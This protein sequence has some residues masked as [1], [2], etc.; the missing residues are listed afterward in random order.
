MGDMSLP[1]PF[2]ICFVCSGN[3]CRSP[4]AEAVLRQMVDE[5]GLAEVAE[6][7]SAGTGD[8][9]IGERADRRAVA[10]LVGAG[11]PDD[12]HR[13]RQFDT[14]WFATRELV[15]AL[16]RHQRTLRAWATKD[17]DRAKVLLLRSFDPALDPDT[18]AS[19]LDVPDPYYDG[20]EM[21][22][23]VLEQIEAACIGLLAHVEEQLDRPAGLRGSAAS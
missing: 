23:A 15:I 1:G 22:R 2:R 20:P 16:D 18:P 7:D 9:H 21:F 8:W 11:Y 6:V 12:G 19:Q 17:T 4:I 10:T 13:A 3:I 14:T 5:A